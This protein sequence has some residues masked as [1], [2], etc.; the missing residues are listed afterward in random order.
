LR[1]VEKAMI[2]G[3]ALPCEFNFHSGRKEATSAR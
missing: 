2:Q 3:V 1:E